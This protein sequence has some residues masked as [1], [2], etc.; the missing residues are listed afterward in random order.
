VI[1]AI[2]QGRALG[3]P[4]H[5]LLIHFPIALFT[6]ALILDVSSFVRDDGNP[7]VRAAFVS[8]VAGLITA[9]LAAAAGFADWSDIRSDHPAKK[10]ANYHM[11]LNIAAVLLYAVSVVLRWGH[12]EAEHTPVIA[13][14]LSLLAAGVLTVSGFLGGHMVYNDGIAV[15]RHRRK[16]E[17]PRTTIKLDSSG[18]PDGL[19]TVGPSEALKDG[20]TLRVEVNG[21]V[22]M[23]TRVGG[24][25]HAIQEFCTHRFGPLSEGAV[26][27]DCVVCPWHKSKFDVTNGNVVDGPAKEG[28]RTFEAMEGEGQIWVKAGETAP[29]SET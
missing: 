2:L 14:L 26:E 28:L 15:G 23:V 5:P 10:T 17:T 12:R 27:G 21:V 1:K 25:C 6:L 8:L 20:Q 3:H 4:L 7:M 24:T 13:F 19:A 29:K 16:T 18:S 11:V 9:L 22:M